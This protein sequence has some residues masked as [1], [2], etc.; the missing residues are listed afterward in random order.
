MV[1]GGKCRPVVGGNP[2]VHLDL[3]VTDGLDY[4]EL[5]LS[6]NTLIPLDL[7]DS[8]GATLL[9]DNDVE[10]PTCAEI[11][12]PQDSTHKSFLDDCDNV[13]YPGDCDHYKRNGWRN[14]LTP[15]FGRLSDGSFVLY[16]TRLE[17]DEN[18]IE[19]PLIDGGGKKVVNSLFAEQTSVY[20][21]SPRPAYYCANAPQDIFNEAHCKLSFDPNVCVSSDSAVINAIPF[22]EDTLKQVFSL[23]GRYVYAV[24]GEKL[25]RCTFWMLSLFGVR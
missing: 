21:D 16:D 22:D 14:P 19:N 6:G 23:T 15:V 1:V 9:L 17:L 20:N 7:S 11:A 5:D 12:D 2:T 24:K 25:F 4:H 3:S 8:Q 13:R 10:S 18:T